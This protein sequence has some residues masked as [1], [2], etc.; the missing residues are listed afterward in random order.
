MKSIVEKKTDELYLEM[1]EI[2]EKISEENVMRNEHYVRKFNLFCITSRVQKQISL[3]HIIKEYQINW[4]S[5][6]VQVDD[7]KLNGMIMELIPI[8]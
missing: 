5:I 8:V 1:K 6:F 4:M 3:M 2:S 7:I